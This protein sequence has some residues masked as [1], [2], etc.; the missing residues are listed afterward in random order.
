MTAVDERRRFLLKT[1]D[2][3]PRYSSFPRFFLSKKWK[4]E[5]RHPLPLFLIPEFHD[6]NA[7]RLQEKN[8]LLLWNCR[9]SERKRLIDSALTA[10]YYYLAKPSNQPKRLIFVVKNSLY[11]SIIPVY[12]YFVSLIHDGIMV[13]RS[14]E[15]KIFV[16]GKNI[17]IFQVY[18]KARF[19]QNLFHNT[20]NTEK[21]FKQRESQGL[22]VI[23]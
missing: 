19:I 2:S 18:F 13:F 3:A 20:P 10:T 23:S 1:H 12:T 11:S 9:L 5:H 7:S 6:P 14:L 15:K 21:H 8:C 4:M 22:D 17:Y 16:K